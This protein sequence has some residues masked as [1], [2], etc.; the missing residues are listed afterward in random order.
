MNWIWYT[1]IWY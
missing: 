1:K